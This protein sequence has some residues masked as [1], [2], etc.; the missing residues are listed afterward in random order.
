MANLRERLVQQ[1][2][3]A[4][5]RKEI[6]R[7]LWDAETVFWLHEELWSR[8]DARLHSSWKSLQSDSWKNA[9][10]RQYLIAE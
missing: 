10:L 3:A 8:P 2:A 4:L 1:G 6:L 9:L 5:E 7:L